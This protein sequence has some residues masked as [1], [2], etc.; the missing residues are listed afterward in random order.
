MLLSH[1]CEYGIQAVLYLAKHHD[2]PYISVKEI[3]EKHN[4]SF[5]F[6]GK[7]LQ[8][9]TQKGLLTSYKGPRGGISLARS[10]QELTVLQVVEAIDGVEFLQKCVVGMPSCGGDHPCALHDKWSIIRQEIYAMLADKSIAQL[11]N[12]K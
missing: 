4:I 10:P 8:K 2:V 3:A 5:H 7:I 11:I 1:T 12:G 9:L 6:L